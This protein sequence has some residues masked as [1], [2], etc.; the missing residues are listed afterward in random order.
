MNEA[1]LQDLIALLSSNPTEQKRFAQK[2]YNERFKF[3]NSGAREECEQTGNSPSDSLNYH[4]QRDPLVAV[5][6]E[7]PVH[8]LMIMMRVQ[9]YGIKEIAEA[10]EYSSIH[11]SN[12]LRQPWAVKRMTELQQ[13]AGVSELQQSIERVGKKALHVIEDLLDLP[14]EQASVKNNAAQ[15]ALNRLLGKPKESLVIADNRKA[16]DL[17]NDELARIAAQQNT[18]T[19]TAQPQAESVGKVSQSCYEAEHSHQAEEAN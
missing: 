11:V 13:E 8:R 19:L 2:C 5:L 17:S 3:D 9:G 1:S 15:Y 7:S 6:H 14:D 18:I 12:V 4:K 10:T 16:D